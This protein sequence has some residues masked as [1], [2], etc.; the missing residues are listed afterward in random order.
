MAA[1]LASC[2][3]PIGPEWTRPI[4]TPPSP[5]NEKNGSYIVS[6]DLQAY[7]PVPVEG[8]IPVKSIT[9]REDMDVAVV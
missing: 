8:M 7:I 2:A 6:Y 4:N 9:G 3:F 5:G 1:L